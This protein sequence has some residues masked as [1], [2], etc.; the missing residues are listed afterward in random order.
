MLRGPANGSPPPIYK[1]DARLLAHL[2]YTS[3]DFEGTNILDHARP[4]RPERACADGQTAPAQVAP[5][6]RDTVRSMILLGHPATTVRSG[7]DVGR[8]V[9]FPFTASASPG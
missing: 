9:R 1:G 5:G 7:A 2:G 3:E 8:P 4:R 6:D